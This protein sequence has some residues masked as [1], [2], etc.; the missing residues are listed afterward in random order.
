MH[1]GV[2]SLVP[3]QA[4][5]AVQSLVG[6]N[7]DERPKAEFASTLKEGWMW[8]LGGKGLAA[9]WSK[10]W[11]CLTDEGNGFGPRLYYFKSQPAMKEIGP[12]GI[13]DL[14][15]YTGIAIDAKR[16]HTWRLEN[17]EMPNVRV[18]TLSAET[19][20]EKDTW[21]EL[22]ASLIERGARKKK[23]E[24]AL[25]KIIEK[26]KKVSNWSVWYSLYI[27]VKDAKELPSHSR[28]LGD[29]DPYCVIKVESSHLRTRTVWKSHEPIWNEDFNINITDP[30][31]AKLTI[32]VW[33][34]EPGWQDVLIG[35]VEIP[36]SKIRSAK[37]P[38]QWYPLVPADSKGYVSGD[39]NLKVRY[40]PPTEGS[41]GS[42]FVKVINARNLASKDSNGLSDP[43]VKLEFNGQKQ[44]SKIK[45]KTLNPFYNEDFEFA[46]PQGSG[47]KILQVTVW[48]WDFTGTDDFMGYFNIDITTLP[49]DEVVDHW[50]TL[51]EDQTHSFCD[52]HKQ[53]KKDKKKEKSHH[54][55][56]SEIKN[57]GSIRLCFHYFEQLILPGA[58]YNDLLVLLLEPGFHLVAALRKTVTPEDLEELPRTL[59]RVFYC[60]GIAEKIIVHLAECEI[61][62]TAQPEV[63]FRGNTLVTKLIDAYM[64]LIGLDYLRETLQPVISSIYDCKSNFEVDPTKIEKGQD[65]SKN[66]ITLETKAS[67]LLEAIVNSIDKVPSGLRDVF[68]ALQEAVLKKWQSPKT[69]N[70]IRYTV[71]SGFFFLRFIGPALT[72]PKRMEVM[73][74]HPDMKTARALTLIA[75]IVQNLS[76]LVEFKDKEAYMKDM[77]PFIL[78]NINTMKSFLNQLATPATKASF[79]EVPSYFEKDMALLHNYLFVNREK[80]SAKLDQ[81]MIDRFTSILDNLNNGKLKFTTSANF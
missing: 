36:L 76:N 29:C 41:N 18:Y 50:Y 65:V 19:A 48:D 12:A 3:A 62:D 34:E 9:H 23:S 8:K 72:G 35:K 1:L 33:D 6:L 71:I 58:E 79:Q 11:F 52:A 74:D 27:K 45:K 2:Q 46:I 51:L 43:Y 56:D 60:K 42:L 57:P 38:E 17:N 39:M 10:R 22:I 61:A 63:I 66:F 77:N 49:H 25:Q 24:T 21:V 59:C 54:K 28:F 40:N 5:Q 78:N 64:K 55:E 37:T 7:K 67:E 44:K 80:I 69:Q 81:P 70:V 26:Q 4:M 31:N 73:N 68:H 75:K 32:T 15:D 53:E 13:V 20:E 47:A 14:Y 30:S 16:K